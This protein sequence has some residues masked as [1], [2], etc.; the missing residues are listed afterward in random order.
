MDTGS[1]LKN[2]PGKLTEEM[3]K[4]I[5]KMCYSKT[6]DEFK[7]E[8]DTLCKMFLVE[9]PHIPLYFETSA[10]FCKKNVNG[11][12]SPSHSWVYNGITDLFVRTKEGIND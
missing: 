1:F 7:S 2:M 6:E 9:Y 3:T 4:Q 11:T 12:P 10:L 5:D 8:I